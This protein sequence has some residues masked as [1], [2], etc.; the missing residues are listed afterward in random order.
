MAWLAFA[1][2]LS[3]FAGGEAPAAPAGDIDASAPECVPFTRALEKAGENA[4]ITGKVVD[5]RVARSGMTY[6]DFCRDYRDCGFA[7]AV[8]PADARRFGNL[9]ALKNREIQITGKV[10]RSGHLA[11]IV[12][13]N[14]EQLLVAADPPE[15][16]SKQKR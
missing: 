5:V 13:R 16:A 4:C 11:G 1:L 2:A 8:A 15:K 10:F 3:A 7:V 14:E 6:L 9:R 12:W